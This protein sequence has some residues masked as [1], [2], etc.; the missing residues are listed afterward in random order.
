MKPWVLMVIL[1]AQRGA[2]KA[3]SLWLCPFKMHLLRWCNSTIMDKKLS[4]LIYRFHQCNAIPWFG[5][6]VVDNIFLKISTCVTN[7]SRSKVRQSA[8]VCLSVKQTEARRPPLLDHLSSTILWTKCHPTP[9]WTKVYEVHYKVEYMPPTSTLPMSPCP[10][11][12]PAAIISLPTPNLGSHQKYYKFY[13]E[14]K[15][16]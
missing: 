13:E 3:A 9:L 12:R 2:R 4:L 11:P 8:T 5:G 16:K 1:A 10:C 14:S 7:M 6:S 15:K